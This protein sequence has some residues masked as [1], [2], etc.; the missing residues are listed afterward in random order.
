MALEMEKNLFSVE[1]IVE[2]VTSRWGY[3]T[4]KKELILCFVVGRDVFV[5]LP[6]GYVQN[7][8]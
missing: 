3:A 2:T 4:L 5:A 7:A 6:T 1:S 8:S